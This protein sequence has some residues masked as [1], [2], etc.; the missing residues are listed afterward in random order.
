MTNS[1]HPWLDAIR[2]IQPHR[3]RGKRAPYK[4]LL[5]LW[6]IARVADGKPP[7][8]RFR[9]AEDELKELM[10]GYRLGRKLAVQYPF[11]YLAESSQLWRV[12]DNSGNNI[13]EMTTP[14]PPDTSQ[15]R[16]ESVRFL[17]N[18]ATGCLAPDFAEAIRNENVRSEIVNELLKLQFP[19]GLHHVMLRDLELEEYV[20][21]KARR[22]DSNFRLAVL[23]AY[24]EQCAFC[25]FDSR[26]RDSA[27][28]IDAAHIM[29]HAQGGKDTVDNGLALCVLHHRL[30]D[31][32]AMGIS[33][34]MLLLV[35]PL[36]TGASRSTRQQVSGLE[37]REITTPSSSHELPHVANVQWHRDEIFV[38][39]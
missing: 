8:I 22:R 5:L 14:F 23:D 36:L 30:F 24:R 31:R 17:R 28:G 27:I 13:H 20:S 38:S 32:G 33:D 25:G 34:N 39:G 29:M 18:E 1:A 37:S 19:E 3:S 2:E 7:T 11:V 15:P 26:L 12:N 6:M 10:T 16:R 35:S 9:D 21:Y 4:T